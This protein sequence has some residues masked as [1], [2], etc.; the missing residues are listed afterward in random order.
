M[1]V[2]A[3]IILFGTSWP[4]VS[5]SSM[6]PAF[7]DRMNLP[8]AVILGLV[9]GASLLLAW[10]EES[11]EGA[12][13]KASFAFGAA[14]LG[15]VVLLLVGLDSWQ[16][17]AL[18][19]SALFAL[20]VSVEK[21]YRSIREDPRW[22]GGAIAHAGLALL[23]LGIIGSGYYGQKVT[24]ALSENEPKE[25]LGYQLT[26]TGPRAF[27]RGKWQFLVRAERNGEA[28]MLFPVMYQSDYNNNLMREPDY[29]SFLTRD[30][31]IEPVSLEQGDQHDHASHH[32]E[33]KRGEPSEIAG[34]NVTFQRFE[35]GQHGSDAMMSGAGFNVGAVLLVERNGKR[36]EVTAVT[37]YRDGAEPRP[38]RVMLS[39]SVHGFEMLGMQVDPE[40]KSARILV[41][42]IGLHDHA[43]DEAKSDVLVIE[44]SVKPFMSTVWAAVVLVFFGLTLSLVRRGKETALP[45]GNKSKSDEVRNP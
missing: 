3:L 2:S 23:F 33:L 45:K 27:D 13:K 26:Y 34:M 22:A 18:A 8:I 16:M 37:T 21:A 32:F 4:I 20:F 6:E 24:A 42:V 19:F 7:Y 38:T 25:V 1:A 28:F 5:N 43:A 39:D 31:Y 41:N 15:L 35:M 40:S 10:K 12:V 14:V 29:V 36:E 9:L 30:F 44:A 17:G 11:L